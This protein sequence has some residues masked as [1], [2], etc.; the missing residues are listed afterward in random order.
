MSKYFLDSYAMIE[1]AKGN[2]KYKKY[3]HEE[4]FTS[5]FNL[6]ELYYALIRD[7]NEEIAK[8]FFFQFKK[9]ILPIKDEHIFD[10]SKFKL[11]N[12]KIC[13][14]YADCIGY[15]IALNYGIKFLTG[16]KEFESLD[17]VEF[18]KK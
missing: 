17:H 11:K 15:L 10:A 16:D 1:I 5:V 6:Y 13:F 12:K 4:T 8:E 2:E 7:Y 18:V 3:L 9:R 14:S